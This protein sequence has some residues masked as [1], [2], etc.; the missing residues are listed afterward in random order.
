[1]AVQVQSWNGVRE[2]FVQAVAQVAQLLRCG[3]K[4]LACQ[5]GGRPEPYDLQRC[6]LF[7]RA[8]VRVLLRRRL[9]L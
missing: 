4:A 3:R 6:P 1:M 5:T 2:P 8:G 9:S 7:G